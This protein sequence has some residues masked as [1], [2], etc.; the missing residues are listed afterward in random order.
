M[1]VAVEGKL[2]FGYARVFTK[3]KPAWPDISPAVDGESLDTRRLNR[4]ITW[5]PTA[6]WF[7]NFLVDSFHEIMHDIA[8]WI[9]RAIAT[10]PK[11]GT[12]VIISDGEIAN[13]SMRFCGVG[14]NWLYA[15]L[16]NENLTLKDVFI[17]TADKYKNYKIIRKERN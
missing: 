8:N 6:I 17:M 14:T 3:I 16:Q 15:T 1:I 4:L 2:L 12:V 7:V 9:A 10:V 11:A 13:S 5:V